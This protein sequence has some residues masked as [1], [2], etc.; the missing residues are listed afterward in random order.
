MATQ[1]MTKGPS[2]ATVAEQPAGSVLDPTGQLD[3]ASAPQVRAELAEFIGADGRNFVVDL[4]KGGFVDL[5][6]LGVLI[7]AR[8]EV[9]Q[10]GGEIRVVVQPQIKTMFEPARLGEVFTFVPPT[11]ETETV[12][13]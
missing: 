3:M 9:R 4:G 7:G 11:N 12:K 1:V 6:G 8:K 5:S 2:D 10:L 13:L